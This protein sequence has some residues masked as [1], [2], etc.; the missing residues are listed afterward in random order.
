MFRLCLSACGQ[1]KTVKK[2]QGGKVKRKIA[3]N[4]K[5]IK[6]KLASSQPKKSVI[7]RVI[8]GDDNVQRT[9]MVCSLDF[10]G[11]KQNHKKWIFV[12]F[13]LLLFVFPFLKSKC[14]K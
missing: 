12:L 7:K 2:A 14:K 11:S 4:R 6:I 1:M 8:N 9:C 5:D 10:S 13:L 3:W